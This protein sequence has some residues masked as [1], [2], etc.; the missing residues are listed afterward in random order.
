MCAVHPIRIGRIVR[1]LRRRKGMR[2]LDLAGHAGLSQQAVS[3]VETG[4]CRELSIVTLERL[5]AALEAELE[6]VVRW[7]GDQLDRVIDAGHADLAAAFALVLAA[8]GWLVELEVTYALCRERGSID[9]LAFHPV[10]V[11]LLVGEIKTEVTSAEGTL[12]RHDEK[13]RLGADIAQQRFNWVS[14]TV[15]RILVLPDA[16]TPRRRVS[17]NAPIFDR[18]YPA[19]GHVVRRWLRRPSGRVAG[20]LFLSPTKTVGVRRELSSRRR[21]ART[22][23]HATERDPGASATRSEHGF[24]D[25]TGEHQHGW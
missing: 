19:R 4:H 5:L 18:A 24:I 15:S 9:V 8:D 25:S 2:Q 10:Y 20:L 13:V 12:R 11:A 7:R 6:L 22:A 16:S 1:T 23:R 17:S 14:T 3:L 21:V